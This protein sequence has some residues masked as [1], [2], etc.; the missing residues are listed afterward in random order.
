MTHST[1]QPVFTPRTLSGERITIPMDRV[2]F[3]SPL[4]RRKGGRGTAVIDGKEYQ[5]RAASCGLSC[6]CDAIIIDYPE[7]SR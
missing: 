4:P 2:T 1:R 6:Y 7:V 5:I 3:A